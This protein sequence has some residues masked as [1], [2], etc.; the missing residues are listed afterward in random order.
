[1]AAADNNDIEPVHAGAASSLFHVEHSFS[2]LCSKRTK[3]KALA[4]IVAL[5]VIVCGAGSARALG[6]AP[7]GVVQGYQPLNRWLIPLYKTVD[8]GTSV[9]IDVVNLPKYEHIGLISQNL[10]NPAS[11]QWYIVGGGAAPAP[12]RRDIPIY[13]AEFNDGGKAMVILFVENAY[14]DA[15]FFQPRGPFP[16]ISPIEL[17]SVP[18]K[19]RLFE[20]YR[21]LGKQHMRAI[22][23]L[24]GF[25][26][27]KSAALSGFSGPQRQNDRGTQT[28]DADETNPEPTFCPQGAAF[29]G[30]RCLP[31]SAQIGF[32][33]PLW[34]CAWLA[35]FNGLGLI[36]KRRI[37]GLWIAGGIAVGL[38]PLLLGII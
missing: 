6:V 21:T 22:R 30:P 37:S 36:G 28:H 25:L 35:I 19:V 9:G 18:L 4:L 16:K 29:S 12:L 23:A 32:L 26:S 20:V 17:I 11:G 1:M 27:G 15:P 8:V 31:L 34:L 3:M 38:I 10:G 14:Q 2:A 33:A 7:K 13:R 5:F 24:Y